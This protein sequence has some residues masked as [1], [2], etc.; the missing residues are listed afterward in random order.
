RLALPAAAP[1]ARRRRRRPLHDQVPRRALRRRRGRAG[2]AGRRAR[3]APRVQPQRDGRGGLAVRLLAGAA[4]PEDPRRAHGP[5]LGQCGTGRGVPGRPPEGRLGA[6]PG[7]ALAPGARRRSQTDVRLRRDGVLPAPG[8]RGRR[9]EGLRAGA[10]VHA[11]RVTRGRGVADRAP[12]PHDARQ[13][14]RLTPGGAG[15]PRPAVRRH[16]GRRRPAGRP[17][18]GPGL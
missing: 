9:A 14:R 10:A 11:G 3:R 4:Q 7:P 8:R 6:V 15:R 5:A 12:G 17:G 1:D 13:R 18:A 2:G 16:R